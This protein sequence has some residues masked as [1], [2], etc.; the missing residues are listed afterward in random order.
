[1]ATHQLSERQIVESIDVA[2]PAEC[3][4]RA[5]TDPEALMAW[6]SEPTQYP[7]T[8]WE[9]DLRPGGTWLSRWKNLA[10]GSE[11]E[12]GG[13]VLELRAPHLLVV[14][15]WDDRYPGLDQTTVRYEIEQ[16]PHGGSRLRVTHSGFDATRLDFDDY[17]GG[18][19]QVLSSLRRHA[20]DSASRTAAGS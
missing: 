11:F 15:W 13:V 16:L 8:H 6:W 12:L 4:F 2:A 3:V 14:S 1:M 20:E 10:D 17:N 19:S 7:A 5:L 9:M 18:W